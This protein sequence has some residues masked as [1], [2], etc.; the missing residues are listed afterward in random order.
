MT[1]SIL[2]SQYIENSFK[3]IETFEHNGMLLM[4][5]LTLEYEVADPPDSLKP[6]DM[7][8]VSSK[9]SVR[10]EALSVFH[11]TIFLI[12]PTLACRHVFG[13]WNIFKTV[14]ITSLRRV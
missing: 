11:I 10:P 5:L 2:H 14:T 7:Y 4:F 1:L 6:T 3:K 12:P 9:N 13:V 8:Y